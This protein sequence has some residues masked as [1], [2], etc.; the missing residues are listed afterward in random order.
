[1]G[2]SLAAMTDVI[3]KGSGRNRTTKV[4]LQKMVDGK[5]SA[6]SFSMA[7]MVKDMNQAIQLGTD[8]GVPTTITNAVRGLLQIGVSTLGASAQLEDIL[9]LIETQSLHPDR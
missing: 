8:C 3:N 2:L 9:G 6:S 1:M 7:L 4:M 5:P